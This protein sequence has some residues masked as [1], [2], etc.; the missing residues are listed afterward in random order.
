M[1]WWWNMFS[2]VMIFRQC[3]RSAFRRQEFAPCLVPW[4]I[5]HVLLVGHSEASH[6]YKNSHFPI[7]YRNKYHAAEEAVIKAIRYLFS[8]LCYFTWITTR[9]GVLIIDSA[10][11]TIA[12]CCSMQRWFDCEMANQKRLKVRLEE[13]CVLYTHLSTQT[14]APIQKLRFHCHQYTPLD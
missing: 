3:S 4:C 7:S 10:M 9:T 14:W 1:C 5:I 13:Q 2:I 11:K 8:W 6:H 12:F